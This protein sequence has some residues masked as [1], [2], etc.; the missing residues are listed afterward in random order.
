M[1]GLCSDFF[2][3]GNVGTKITLLDVENR[4]GHGGAGKEGDEL[5]DWD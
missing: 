5:G 2:V 4:E 1:L 3:L